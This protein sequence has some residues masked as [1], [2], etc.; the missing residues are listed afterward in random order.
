[1]KKP[2]ATL[3]Q[4]KS[5][6]KKTSPYVPTDDSAMRSKPLRFTHACGDRPLEGYTVKR[7]IGIGGF[8]EVYFALSDAGKEVALKRI[9]R[10]IDIE[11]R[12]VSQCLN[13]KHVNLIALWDIRTDSSQNGWVVMEY[14]PGGS[15]KDVIED[16]HQ[17]MELDDVKSWFRG[18]AAGTSY[19]H[20]SGIVHRDLK[21]GN[22]FLDE[23]EQVVKI[24]DYGLS[25]LMSCGRR[26][27][28]TETV[29]TFHYMAPEIGRGVYGKEIDLYALGIIL[30]EMLTGD[31]PFDGESSQEIIMKHLTAEPDYDQ[32]LPA[33]KGVIRKALRKDPDHRYRNVDEMLSDFER[34]CQDPSIALDAAE[35]T[36][37]G[38]QSST[39]T[40]PQGSVDSDS[41]SSSSSDSTAD[42]GP[43]GDS[44]VATPGNA[45]GTSVLYI[46]DEALRLDDV[47]EMV[48]GEVQDIVEAIPIDDMIT[49]VVDGIIEDDASDEDENPGASVSRSVGT[50]RER[51]VDWWN[52]GHISTPIK[53]GLVILVGA[54]LMS[55]SRWLIPVGIIVAVSAIGFSFTRWLIRRGRGSESG[56]GLREDRIHS[57]GKAWHSESVTKSWIQR[58][59]ELLGGW[60]LA[61]M[62]VA[63]LTLLAQAVRGTNVPW[64]GN[65][66]AFFGW[67][68]T[69]G[70]LATCTLLMLSKF[71]G[72]SDGD[73]IRRRFTLMIAGIAV[74]LASAGLSMLLQIDMTT[75][76]A[77]DHEFLFDAADS[78][79]S[80]SGS[81]LL[82]AHLVFF[83]G[84]FFAFRWWKQ[85]DP[86]RKTRL[87][88]WGLGLC[89]VIGT[90]LNEI[91]GF[92]FPWMT[93]LAGVISVSLQIASTWVNQSERGRLISRAD[94]VVSEA[95]A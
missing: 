12:G 75:V 68:T 14:V 42:P 19:L 48:F 3:E 18:I 6:L 11:M 79:K 20:G 50:K 73:P 61:A 46:D 36:S 70:I 47:Q 2:L 44:S 60:I 5:G 41:N 86:L 15:L 90:L 35:Q 33:F 89:L 23:D 56:K 4:G 49:D 59:K 30:F 55:N 34:A 80:E 17:G 67:L 29:G 82:A 62:V 13:L 83:A 63:S 10:H 31:V 65:Q 9:Q 92:P 24:G 1:M 77:S 27:G 32:V 91:A 37:S 76:A 81:P 78:M 7:G 54:L 87:S 52:H 66:W 72:S 69:V 58:T 39:T 28:Q 93:V 38:G 25:K 21:P 95:A 45:A 22:I 40:D 84:F 64:T 57:I 88:F 8:G 74:G 26:S 85:T 16:H 53:V 94:S 71:W 51:F 43:V